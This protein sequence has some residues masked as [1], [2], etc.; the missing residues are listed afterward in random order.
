[1]A[2]KA[3][4]LEDD[5]MAGL[6]YHHLIRQA[7]SCGTEKALPA[8]RLLYDMPVYELTNVLPLF[9]DWN[10]EWRRPIPKRPPHDSLWA[11]WKHRDV[12]GQDWTLACRLHKVENSKILEWYEPDGDPDEKE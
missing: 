5:S 1:M 12:F 4:T 3:C 2:H 6:L 7:R 11:E 8:L 10:S 9:Q